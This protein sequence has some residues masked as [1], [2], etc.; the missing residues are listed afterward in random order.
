[1]GCSREDREKNGSTTSK[2]KTVT[3]PTLLPCVFND[4]PTLSSK[5]PHPASA[6][7]VCT[8]KRQEPLDKTGSFREVAPGGAARIKGKNTGKPV[9]PGGFETCL[10]GAVGRVDHLDFHLHRVLTPLDP[11]FTLLV[12]LVH[13]THC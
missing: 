11:A 9:A 1:L 7:G 5:K 8:K 3:T 10:G 4:S 12:S 2:K 13:L 6:L